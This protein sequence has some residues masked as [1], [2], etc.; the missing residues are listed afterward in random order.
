MKKEALHVI[1]N[2]IK[3]I[4]ASRTVYYNGVDGKKKRFNKQMLGPMKYIE[5]L[6]LTDI[7][8]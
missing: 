8:E 1:Q 3:A 4:E 2:T 6:I 7:G 5:G